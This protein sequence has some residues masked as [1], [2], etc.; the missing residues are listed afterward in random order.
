MATATMPALTSAAGR[1]GEVLPW[2]IVD[3]P[4]FGSQKKELLPME[5][6]WRLVATNNYDAYLA[7]VGVTPLM[8][9]MVIR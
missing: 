2:N 1:V 6:S 7:A 3:E 5:G 8:A 9:A 4:P